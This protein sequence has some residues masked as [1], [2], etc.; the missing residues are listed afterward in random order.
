MN[1]EVYTNSGEEGDGSLKEL[2]FNQYLFV[3]GIKLSKLN[4][5]M[6]SINFRKSNYMKYLRE[7]K[8]LRKY[9]LCYAS[10]RN[11]VDCNYLITVMFYFY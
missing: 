6:K 9:C 11:Q 8:A 4:F 7:V 5:F 3:E 2:E 1:M 10:I